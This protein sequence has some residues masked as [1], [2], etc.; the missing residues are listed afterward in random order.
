MACLGTH[1]YAILDVSADTFREIQTKLLAA[2]YQHTFIEDAAGELVI[3]L[4]GIAIRDE[5]A[6]TEA[7]CNHLSVIDPSFTPRRRES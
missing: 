1:T 2:G 5:D 6:D 7:D 4:H 3:D